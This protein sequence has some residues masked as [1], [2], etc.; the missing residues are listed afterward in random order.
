M[1]GLPWNTNVDV[2]AVGCVISEVYL[3]HQLLP[4][5]IQSDREHLAVIDKVF[6][7]FPEQYAREVEQK[8]AGTFTFGVRGP[9]VVFQPGDLKQLEQ[10]DGVMLRRLEELRPIWVCVIHVLLRRCEEKRGSLF[11]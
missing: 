11:C 2:F 3:G 1:I 9:T 7:P 5:D 6:G 4:R 8:F 10:V